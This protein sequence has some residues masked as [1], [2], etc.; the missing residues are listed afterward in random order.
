MGWSCRCQ[1]AIVPHR[2][3]S[4]VTHLTKVTKSQDKQKL[5]NLKTENRNP[6]SLIFRLTQSLSSILL[7]RGATSPQSIHSPSIDCSVPL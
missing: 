6:N 5:Q 2:Q 4:E 1:L 3:V 7:L